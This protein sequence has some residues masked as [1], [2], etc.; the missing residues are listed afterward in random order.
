MGAGMMW[1]MLSV[2]LGWLVMLG[3]DA[4]FIYLV[5]TA[6]RTRR[7]ARMPTST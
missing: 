5:V 1:M 4:V 2:G 3:L 6:V 7:T